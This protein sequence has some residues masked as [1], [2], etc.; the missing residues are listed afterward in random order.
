MPADAVAR[1][2]T[3]NA[4]FSVAGEA[5]FSQAAPPQRWWHLYD[6]PRLDIYIDEGLA[7]NRDLRVADANLLEASALVRVARAGA[8]PTTTLSA[9]GG[10]SRPLESRV[11]LGDSPGYTLGGGIAYPLDLAGGIRR[12]IEQAEDQAEAITAVRDE[13]RITVAAGIARSYV[14]ACSANRT[15]EATMHAL[16]I[17]R[18][19][20]DATER[21]FR[22]GRGA[23]AF[24]VTRARA[25]VNQSA[26]AL[27]LILADHQ[28]ALLEL[29]ALLG[30]VP[31]DYPKEAENCMEP[32]PLQRPLPIGDGVALLRRRPDLRAAERRLAAATAAIGV[33]TAQLYPQVSLGGA[34]TFGGPPAALAGGA[35]LGLSVGPLLSWTFP[36]QALARS[37]IA[38]AGA[39]AQ[40]TFAQFD[41]IVLQALRETE[42]AL[43]NCARELDHQRELKLAR[44]NDAEA[45]S[46]AE[47][48][49]RFGRTDFLSLLTAESNLAGAESALAESQA[50]LANRQID[51]FLALGGGWE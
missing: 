14:T 44:D 17:Q 46:Q 48:L 12:G 28:A 39:A 9:G 15:Y 3:A 18:R 19:T 24:D 13:A 22:G 29:G 26:A 45:V 11:T 25:A 35:P 38:A 43:S 40:A 23:T 1:S 36:N 31:R 20:L 34:A 50:T 47:R 10:L 6:D 5:A 8:L 41:S 33:E 4:P 2:T 42:T 7:A 37:R 27:S 21:L 49:Y 30:R 32:P 16:D 51:V